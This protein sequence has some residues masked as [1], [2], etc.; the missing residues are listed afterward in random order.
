MQAFLPTSA[1]PCSAFYNATVELGVANS[2]TQFTVSDFGRTFPVNSGAG[3]DHGWGNHQLVVGGGV[4]GQ[5]LYG[6]FPTLAVNGPDDT[7]T[8][9]WIPKT[10]CDEYFATMAKWFGV[11]T[12]SMG[13]V[14]PNIGRFAHPDL[15]FMG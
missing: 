11:P 14:F 4:Q 2:V 3:S 10:S 13:T 9:R 15:G 12:S 8:G 1:P 6:T 5:K 7:S